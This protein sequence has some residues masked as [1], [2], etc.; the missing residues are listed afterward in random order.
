MGRQFECRL[1]AVFSLCG[2]TTGWGTAGSRERYEISQ[3]RKKDAKGVAA[4]RQTVEELAVEVREGRSTACLFV[5]RCEVE[6][7]RLCL[8]MTTSEATILLVDDSKEDRIL[9]A[10]ALADAGLTGK[11]DEVSDA[12][13]AESYFLRKM[14][15]GSV[16]QLVILDLTLPKRS[17]LELLET[18]NANGITK[19]TCVIVLS[20]VLPESDIARLQKLGA[21]RVFEKPLDLQEFFVLGKRVK[22]LA[23][24]AAAD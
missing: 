8:R 21:V 2:L 18:W 11:I 6:I 1:A 15:E 17:G 12:E 3:C 10:Q 20:S 4:R 16:P 14:G 5:R 22:E 19:L 13:G 7:V 24:V 9:L 23:S